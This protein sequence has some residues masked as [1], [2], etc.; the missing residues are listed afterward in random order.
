MSLAQCLNRVFRTTLSA[1]D[2]KT[3]ENL[4]ILAKGRLGI[5][6]ILTK[7]INKRLYGHCLW[8]SDPLND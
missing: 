7:N 2:D 5:L 6:F 4:E 1:L 8:G 3:A